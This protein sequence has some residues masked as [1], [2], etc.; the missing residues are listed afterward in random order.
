MAG[1]M[2]L[3]SAL[4][5]LAHWAKTPTSPN[6][7]CQRSPAILPSAIIAAKFQGGAQ[8]ARLRGRARCCRQGRRAGPPGSPDHTSQAVRDLTNLFRCR[9]SIHRSKLILVVPGPRDWVWFFIADRLPSLG[10]PHPNTKSAR[11]VGRYFITMSGIRKTLGR[12]SF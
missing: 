10:K 6:P 7:N 9:S 4:S 5:C 2:L 3:S 8:L 1:A 12:F 11:W